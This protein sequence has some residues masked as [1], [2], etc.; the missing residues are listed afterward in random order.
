MY[1]AH[2]TF[3]GEVQQCSTGQAVRDGLTLRYVRLHHSRVAANDHLHNR[4]M[5]EQ[6]WTLAQVCMLHRQKAMQVLDGGGDD[7]KA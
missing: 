5:S 2:G 7:S 1:G 6:G 4:E 3:D